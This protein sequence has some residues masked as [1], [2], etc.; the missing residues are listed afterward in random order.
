MKAGK[1]AAA[2]GGWAVIRLSSYVTALARGQ[3][4]RGVHKPGEHESFSLCGPGAGLPDARVA[5]RQRASRCGNQGTVPKHATD[6]VG[7]AA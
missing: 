6:T 5:T 2:Q 3:A 1:T 4:R 7:W